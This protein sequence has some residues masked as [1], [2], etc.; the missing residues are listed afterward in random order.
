MEGLKLW[1]LAI[2]FGLGFAGLNV[3]G[4]INPQAFG[5][6]ANRF[7]RNTPI[8]YPMMILA[9][10][11]FLSYVR[12]EN[13]AD[14]TAMKPFL[15]SLFI[16]V[17]LGACF[18]LKD[19]LPVRAA[20]ALMLLSAKLVVDTARWVPSD[21]RLVLV[22]WAY[23]WVIAGMWLTISPWR[24]R[25]WIQWGTFSVQRIRAFSSLH[26]AFGLFVAILG[27]TVLRQANQQSRFAPISP[28]SVGQTQLV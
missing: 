20:A 24:L 12:Q 4:L 7:P 15:Y 2:V 28:L 27:L 3:Y 23:I 8:G 17:G 6:M 1:H 10:V 18:F 26:V 9:T 21:W 5:A 22:T 25:D 13:V 11:W 19:F 14:F 16:V